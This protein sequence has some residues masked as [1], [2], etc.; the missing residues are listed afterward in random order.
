MSRDNQVRAREAHSP[1]PQQPDLSQ[2]P[3]RSRRAGDVKPPEENSFLW[4]ITFTDIIGL[5]LTFFVLMYSMSVTSEEAFE[6]VSS[7]MQS[8]FN[9]VY[10][11]AYDLAP[12]DT[13]SLEKVDFKQA[14][15]IPYLNVLMESVIKNNDILKDVTIIRQGGELVLSMPHDML[16]D[17]GS[18][19]VKATGSRVLYALGGALSRIKNKVEVIGHADPRP[20]EGSAETNG[21]Q[22]NWELS[23]ARAAS[24]GAI[25]ERVGYQEH[26]TIHGQS[27]GRY[28]DLTDIQDEQQRLDLSRRV[29]IVLMDHDGSRKKDVFGMG[30]Q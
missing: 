6:E 17:S 20:V 14:L 27:S 23:L 18:A 2:G 26:I 12:M 1:P 21:F 11:A 25:L 22:S 30:A 13:I 10:G 8:E 24:V 4:L 15:D 29:D 5:M 16:F 3:S 19:E 28:D 7:S 9:T